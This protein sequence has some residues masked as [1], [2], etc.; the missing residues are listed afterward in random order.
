[1]SSIAELQVLSRIQNKYQQLAYET[2]PNDISD[3]LANPFDNATFLDKQYFQNL[4]AQRAMESDQDYSARVNL[5]LQLH[6]QINQQRMTIEA[7]ID[8][9]LRSKLAVLTG[10]SQMAS[11]VM[12]SKRFTA[13]EKLTIHSSW[14]SFRAYL[15]SKYGTQLSIGTINLCIDDFL[16]RPTTVAIIPQGV[17]AA[18]VAA[19]RLIRSPVRKTRRVPAADDDDT[20]MTLG[21]TPVRAN[22]QMLATDSPVKIEA[23]PISR[24]SSTQFHCFLCKKSMQAS[25]V[26]VH[27]R[28][29]KHLSNLQNM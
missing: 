19:N 18:G 28:S 14:S 5:Y 22:L 26:A 7:Q 6:P 23:D 2:S 12:A 3:A 13:A 16:R 1:M 25:S 27:R 20:S 29:G 24:I 4:P 15:I 11:S 21:R 9:D 8:S 17:A 10:S